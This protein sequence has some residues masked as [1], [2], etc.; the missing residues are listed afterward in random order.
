MLSDDQVQDLKDAFPEGKREKEK[1]EAMSPALRKRAQRQREKAAKESA[2]GDENEFHLKNRLALSAEK[3]EAL[4]VQDQK[5]RDLLDDM[6][7]AAE[8]VPEEL[9]DRLEFISVQDVEKAV[10]QSVQ[11]HGVTHLGYIHRTE[12]PADWKSTYWRDSELLKKL[13]NEGP[14]TADLV[15][16]GLLTALP[17]FRAVEFL[18]KAG[19]SFWKAGEL[20]GYKEGSDKVLRYK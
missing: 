19:W 2:T 9:N 18:Q 3:L 16:Y 6:T 14:Q 11:E 15:K 1:K 7:L 8:P 4:V 12:I 5:I 17:D 20:A 13:V 10:V